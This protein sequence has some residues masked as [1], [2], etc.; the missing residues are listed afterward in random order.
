MYQGLFGPGYLGGSPTPNTLS[1]YLIPSQSD[2]QLGPNGTGPPQ[3][4][5]VNPFSGISSTHSSTVAL[6]ENKAVVFGTVIIG[7]LEK[8]KQ[9]QYAF[10]APYT[11]T[12]A[13]KVMWDSYV[14]PFQVPGLLPEEGVPNFIE[15]HKE[16]QMAGLMRRGQAIRTNQYVVQSEK[17]REELALMVKAMEYNFLRAIVYDKVAA[18]LGA[19]KINTNYYLNVSGGINPKTLE[20]AFRYSVANFAALQKTD[21]EKLITHLQ[22]RAA[23]VGNT[24][25]CIVVPTEAIGF[26]RN[27]ERNTTYHL[28]GERGIDNRVSLTN[29]QDT[30][31]DIMDMGPLITTSGFKIIQVDSWLDR[32]RQ[33]VNPL[34]TRTQI[35]EWYTTRFFET[36]HQQDYDYECSKV[37]IYDED[38]NQWVPIG[39]AEG[40]D[41]LK[42]LIF[43][44]E[45]GRILGLSEISGKDGGNYI[46]LAGS[47]PYHRA[48]GLGIEFIGEFKDDTGITPQMI[49]H[50]GRLL[51]QNLV[52]KALCTETCVDAIKDLR[53]GYDL[54]FKQ[55]SNYLPN[56]L[57]ELTP[58]KVQR[59]LDNYGSIPIYDSP[60][61]DERVP[62]LPYDADTG[63][64]YLPDVY[65]FLFENE[66]NMGVS[67]NI[68]KTDQILLY[69]QNQIGIRFLSNSLVSMDSLPGVND[70]IKKV[71]SNFGA[72]VDIINNYLHQWKD[73]TNV[74]SINDLF[75]LINYVKGTSS[76]N[77]FLNNKLCL[78]VAN[79]KLDIAR[80]LFS[81]FKNEYKLY[82]E[83]FYNHPK[84]QAEV[85][86]LQYVDDFKSLINTIEKKVP[87]ANAGTVEHIF[88]TLL[89]SFDLLKIIE[90]QLKEN[91][92]N[93]STKT[94]TPVT[95]LRIP[96]KKTGP[97]D[98][99]VVL[100]DPLSE[101]LLRVIYHILEEGNKIIS[102]KN[103]G[104]IILENKS[105][106]M[107]F[108]YFCFLYGFMRV[109]DQ[110]ASSVDPFIYLQESSLKSRNSFNGASMDS[111]K[112]WVPMMTSVLDA[113]IPIYASWISDYKSSSVMDLLWQ[114]NYL[115]KI[116]STISNNEAVKSFFGASLDDPL[117]YLK[118][119]K[120]ERSRHLETVFLGKQTNVYVTSKYGTPAS[121]SGPTSSFPGFPAVDGKMNESPFIKTS[122]EISLQDVLSIHSSGINDNEF[123]FTVS[124]PNNPN[125]P[126]E[127]DDFGNLVNLLE[128]SQI[129]G[130]AG[131]IDKLKK[132]STNITQKESYNGT[133]YDS[134][135]KS[136]INNVDKALIG[137]NL[138]DK[139][140]ANKYT[141]EETV[142]TSNTATVTKKTFV[143]GKERSPSEPSQTASDSR[144]DG[145]YL[146]YTY[147]P[148]SI[149]AIT[150]LE[151]KLNDLE[152]L[153][154]KNVNKPQSDIVWNLY[155]AALARPII[156]KADGSHKPD[157]DKTEKELNDS[158]SK[159]RTFISSIKKR[160]ILPNTE[161]LKTQMGQAIGRM[162]NLGNDFYQD[163]FDSAST[164]SKGVSK[165]PKN[166][167]NLNSSTPLQWKKKGNNYNLDKMNKNFLN[168]TKDDIMLMGKL[169]YMLTP[170]N[171][172]ALM[173]LCHM[174]V[175][176]PVDIGYFR[177]HMEYQAYQIFASKGGKDAIARTF[178]N[179][180]QTIA[181]EGSDPLTTGMVIT[182]RVM[183]KTI[184]MHPEN[185]I[186]L[187]AG[188]IR[189]Y[190]RGAG[191]EIY[192]GKHLESYM[193][194][195]YY[196]NASMFAVLLTPNEVK[197]LRKMSV[198]D[199]SGRFDIYD[200]PSFGFGQL[201]ID[202]N[203][204]QVGPSLD[205]FSHIYGFRNRGKNSDHI[206]LFTEHYPIN[207][208]MNLY[209]LDQANSTMYNTI[210]FQGEYRYWDKKA[211]RYC[212]VQG[213]GHWGGETFVGR[214]ELLR[215]T[216][217][218]DWQVVKKEA[219]ANYSSN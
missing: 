129:Q 177:P 112:N 153:K 140:L 117:I 133:T 122:F 59:L 73:L 19:P 167:T 148:F 33:Q 184:V 8:R 105:E 197:R 39:A 213:R 89:F 160:Q 6:Y 168:G 34:L 67:I 10:L 118:H 9:D 211:Q 125:I 85:P 90:G 172:L 189:Q 3:V 40:L 216:H 96:D 52:K 88:N 63:A 54:M 131:D 151:K 115:K 42:G 169:I 215:G 17:G 175:P 107:S 48:D 178:V 187:P 210:V 202:A 20:E 108:M 57:M 78:W 217:L 41:A 58:E 82:L 4:A 61:R 81:G 203:E 130:K 21:F 103:N 109:E 200:A 71:V 180:E 5:T 44:D 156:P 165:R 47:S 66:E 126:L 46:G 2:F 166:P 30:V 102:K 199:I 65:N 14:F 204:N 149:P 111:D 26:L 31:N 161:D 171:S 219:Q 127:R 92:R 94:K 11:K 141:L 170:F 132:Q 173:E 38:K 76:N 70:N 147:D 120:K 144:S 209:A 181:T 214:A 56:L 49:E 45:N 69:L 113:L 182:N 154:Y 25:N 83:Y 158:I 136:L 121:K 55:S 15:F 28:A 185:V 62:V 193:P 162:N 190:N 100:Y 163:I 123:I 43:D 179:E 1:S 194:P 37:T 23:L 106:A 87:N 205:L 99:L 86:L 18:F 174:N 91:F 195:D 35:G 68:P 176:L 13:M 207:N 72:I 192:S 135:L 159:L 164:S 206:N 27:L 188:F 75:Q 142:I 32:H 51:L 80:D 97:D 101:D 119:Q 212:T 218:K 22:A 137:L 7:E 134:K 98:D 198:V 150:D 95:I 191:T 104:T 77:Q 138:E 110:L 79:P 183:Y 84:A 157:V 93:A 146:N 29:A 196:S 53:A 16:S 128:T 74:Q 139:I 116:F 50:S 208:G 60:N 36:Y 124:D 201:G 155:S 24:L 143:N 64:T 114:N 152:T 186:N 12:D 145:T